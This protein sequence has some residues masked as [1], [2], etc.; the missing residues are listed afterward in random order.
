L[1]L[2]KA[3]SD[4]N[5]TV[6]N[7]LGRFWLCLGPLFRWFLFATGFGFIKSESDGVLC[8]L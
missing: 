3:K 5:S 6:L 2:W 4:E 8:I 7:H 1:E